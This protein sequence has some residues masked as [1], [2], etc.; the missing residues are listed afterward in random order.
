MTAHRPSAVRRRE[1]ADA[2]LAILGEAGLT[3]LTSATIAKKVGVTDAALF[4][5]FQSKHEVIAAA[6]DRAEEILFEGFPPKSQDPLDRLGDFF[7]RRVRTLRENP[8]V[9]KL[10]MSEHLAEVAP[11]ATARVREFRRRSQRFVRACLEEAATRPATRSQLAPE[12]ATVLVLGSIMAL[13]HGPVVV[14]LRLPTAAEVWNA[15]ERTLRGPVRA[16]RSH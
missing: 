1:I 2:A 14:R 5:H 16:G 13:A 7:R 8:G 10:M 12:V 4:R 3:G 15:L 11:W 9:A 6:I